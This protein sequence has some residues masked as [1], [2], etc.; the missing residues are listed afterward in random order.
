[1]YELVE[2][3]VAFMNGITVVD[4]VAFAA[5]GTITIPLVVLIHEAG[6]ILA[7]LVLRRRIAEPTVGDDTP[8]VTVRIGGF[9]LRLGAITGKGDAA[10]FIV[11]DAA[12]AGPRDTFVIAL[13]GPLASLV[14]ALVTGVL[15]S[16]SGR[17]RDCRGCSDWRR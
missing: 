16:G 6:H 12:M 2:A 4:A 7:T 3:F 9:R 17:R 10:G 5:A 11:Y 8:A 14:G 15:L 1:V 13:A